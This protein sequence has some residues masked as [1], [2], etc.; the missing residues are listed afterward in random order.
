L[1][2]VFSLLSEKRKWGLWDR[3]SGCVSPLI[4]F[5]PIG[6]F[7]WNLIERSCR[8]NGTWDHEILHTDRSSNDEQL[9]IRP[10]LSKTEKYE[11]DG[12]LNVKI[13]SL[14]CGDNLWTVSL[15]QM[16]VGV[17]RDHGH[18]EK[19]YLNYYFFWRSF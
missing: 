3:Q 16:N 11:H 8:W 19:F 17:V 15:K 12:R 9:L 18:T 1:Y 7:L 13:H 14:F 4:T 10:F 6:R 5:E 2:L